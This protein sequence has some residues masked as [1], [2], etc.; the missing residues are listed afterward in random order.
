MR[1]ARH[2]RGGV[3]LAATIGFALAVLAGCRPPQAAFRTVVLGDGPR[4][5]PMVDGTVRGTPVPLLL[6]T[7][8]EWHFLADSTAWGC[9]VETDESD[10]VGSDGIGQ[11]VYA[12]RAREPELRVPGLSEDR[13]GTTAVVHSPALRFG[14]FWGGLAPQ[15]LVRSAERVT[16][17]FR[18]GRL[19]IAPEDEPWPA[20][21]T[22]RS[23]GGTLEACRFDDGS[24]DRGWNYLVA[25][26][27]EGRPAR[28]VVDSGA[29]GTTLFAD[30]AAGRELAAQAELDDLLDEIDREL[31]DAPSGN[32]PPRT[33]EVWQI[34]VGG[35][36]RAVEIADVA[37]ELG[38]WRRTIPLSVTERVDAPPCSGDGVLGFDVLR[39]CELSLGLEDGQWRCSDDPP[40]PAA[41]A[42]AVPVRLTAVEATAACGA[43]AEELRPEVHGG[44]LP[45]TYPS[46]L[47]A[48]AV[49]YEDVEAHARRIEQDCADRGWAT[50]RVRRPPL[51]R[52]TDELRVLFETDEGPRYRVGA[53]TIRILDARE[54]EVRRM[55][56]DELPWWRQRPGV[57]YSETEWTH[58]RFD[59]WDALEPPLGRIQVYRY[60]VLPDEAAGTVELRMEAVLAEPEDEPDE[61]F[62]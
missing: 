49:L 7:G 52:A 44:E 50:A 51:A 38:D 40:A 62:R 37:V 58:D 29:S 14:R 27:V 41:P 13:L 19:A 53:V 35:E 23:A 36:G 20:T 60:E 8:A 28:L 6:D 5:L 21:A 12:D 32:E 18:A 3:G 43:T 26:T 46:L 16:L 39:F 55:E 56:P 2:I 59:L 57:W 31:G 24:S 48:F 22:E 11:P 9:G 47:D 61:S 1:T 4:T 10:G 30:A 42:A 33:S 25:A 15:R 17:D 34:W 54:E 45:M